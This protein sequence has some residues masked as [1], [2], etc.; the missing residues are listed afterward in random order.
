MSRLTP[1]KKD[2]SSDNKKLTV[3]AISSGLPSRFKGVA[4]A[5]LDLTSSLVKVS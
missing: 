4:L 1:V 5:T 3:V 2:D